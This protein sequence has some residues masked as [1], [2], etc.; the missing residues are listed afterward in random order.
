[1]RPRVLRRNWR[2]GGVPA[3]CGGCAAQVPAFGDRTA[4]RPGDG[5]HGQGRGTH[6]LNRSRGAVQAGKA[7]C[8][9]KAV[10]ETLMLGTHLDDPPIGVWNGPMPFFRRSRR[11]MEAQATSGECL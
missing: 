10:G 3:I 2:T 8:D 6:L 1:M 7:T 11:W 9:R 4:A 5:R